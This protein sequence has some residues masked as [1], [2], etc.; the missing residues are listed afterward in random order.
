MPN[1]KHYVGK[2][3][4]LDEALSRLPGFEAHITEV[5]Y[6]YWRR[7][8]EIERELPNTEAGNRPHRSRRHSGRRAT[9]TEGSNSAPRSSVNN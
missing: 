1:E 9:A 3:L 8:I 4:E 2:L 6:L 5:S 7:T